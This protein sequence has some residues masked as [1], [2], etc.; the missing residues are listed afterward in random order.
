MLLSLLAVLGGLWRVLA[1]REI[2]PTGAGGVLT[3][4][5]LLAAT[6]GSAAGL[7]SS[8]GRLT[9]QVGPLGE[10]VPLA[11]NLWRALALAELLLATI[12]IAAGAIER[13]SH[14]ALVPL[15]MGALATVSSAVAQAAL[16][17]SGEALQD[18]PLA[19]AAI[20]L[21]AIV[22]GIAGPAL[23]ADGCSRM[24]QSLSSEALEQDSDTDPTD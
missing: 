17:A 24:L 5:W 1:L 13:R 11:S 2:R 22:G 8:M 18:V 9:G 21:V 10:W 16:V 6:A 12:W 4:L 7:A 23:I 19:I 14:W 15:G 3:G 20:G